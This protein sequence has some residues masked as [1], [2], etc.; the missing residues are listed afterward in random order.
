MR[1]NAC[2]SPECGTL[3]GMRIRHGSANIAGWHCGAGRDS[4]DSR[5]HYVDSN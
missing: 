5:M 4:D 3:S 2:G 1:W